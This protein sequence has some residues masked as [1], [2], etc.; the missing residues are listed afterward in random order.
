M[1]VGEQKATEGM[2]VHSCGLLVS[3]TIWRVRFD[4]SVVSMRLAIKVYNLATFVEG[5]V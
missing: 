4:Q 1:R 5:P 2:R 3:V